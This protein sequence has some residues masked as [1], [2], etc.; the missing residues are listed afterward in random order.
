MTQ[1]Q[2]LLE[3]APAKQFFSTLGMLRPTKQNICQ[4]TFPKIIK[5]W[6]H[7]GYKKCL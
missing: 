3:Y 1:L 4:K 5:I 6:D 2:L 7:T